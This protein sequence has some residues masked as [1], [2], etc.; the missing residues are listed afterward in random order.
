MT[1][2]ALKPAPFRRDFRDDPSWVPLMRL[3]FDRI[4]RG[5]CV[6]CAGKAAGMRDD[7]PYCEEHMPT[8]SW[9]KK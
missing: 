4:K 8:E 1:Y 3:R 9:P 2:R 6:V 7:R 5:V